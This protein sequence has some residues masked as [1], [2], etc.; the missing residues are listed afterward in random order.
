MSPMYSRKKQTA[1][2]VLGVFYGVAL[3]D[4]MGMPSEMFTRD[5]IHHSFGHIDRLLPGS[6]ENWISRGFRAGE[7]TDDTMTTLCVAQAIVE[8]G[9]VDPEKI[10]RGI[11][12]WS[13]SAAKSKTVIGPSTRRAFDQIKAGTPLSETG[14]FGITNGA[15][16]RVGPVGIVSDWENLSLLVDNV[17][18][19][20]LPT[21]NTG[22]AISA[23]A[24][25]AAAISRCIDGAGPDEMLETALAGAELGAVRGNHV[26]GPSV[27]DRIRL[28]MRLLR[29][30]VDVEDAFGKIYRILGTTIASTESV[31]AAIVLA[32]GSALDPQRCAEY[33]ANIGGDTDTIGAISCGICGAATGSSA[34]PPDEIRQILEIN[35]I[36]PAAL[37]PELVKL[38]EKSKGC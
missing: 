21:H 9:K 7:V 20:C 24:A 14:R 17:E 33:A 27:A 28:G 16:M 35:N 23:A 3:G 34:F 37:I 36:D 2:A 22:T 26:C 10:I 38:R 25:V 13:E 8:A 12:E 32:Y 6:D 15:S 30:S 5:Q 18:L 19:A 31:P 29:E 11:M 1:D 4:A